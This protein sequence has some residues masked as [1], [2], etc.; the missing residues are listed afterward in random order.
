MGGWLVEI[1]PS[2]QHAPP[3]RNYRFFFGP[4]LE[5]RVTFLAV[6][7]LVDFFLAVDFFFAAGKFHPLYLDDPNDRESGVS[8]RS[9]QASPPVQRLT[10]K[11]ENRRSV[12]VFP[13]ARPSV[14][15]LAQFQS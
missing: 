6:F 1:D 15:F 3:V 13:G 2:T 14:R 9:A 5:V 11:R 10:G 4:P 7:L 8:N 12:S